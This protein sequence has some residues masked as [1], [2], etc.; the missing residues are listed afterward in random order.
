M[1]MSKW[2]KPFEGLEKWIEEDLPAKG[3]MWGLRPQAPV[4]M[5]EE[6]GEIK[7]ELAVPGWKLEELKVELDPEDRTLVVKGEESR[8][9]E[10]KDRDYYYQQISRSSFERVI[11]LPHEVKG[12]RVQAEFEDGILHITLDKSESAKEQRTRQ[13]PVKK[14]KS[15]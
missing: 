14:R 11:R 7:V 1:S 3:A 13:I 15:S 5:W 9:E 6:D 10:R 8:K 12:D 4:D 2:K